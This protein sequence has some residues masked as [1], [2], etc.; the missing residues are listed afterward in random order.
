MKSGYFD[1]I[2]LGGGGA[3]MLAAVTAANL[4]KKVAIITKE[5][6]G[7]GNTRLSAGMMACPGAL[8]DDSIMSYIED[9]TLSGEGLSEPSLVEY[10]GEKS[11]NVLKDMEGYGILL[12]R[13]KEGY[14]SSKAVFPAGG[15][16]K[17]RTI[18]NVGGGLSISSALR[19][20]VLLHKISVFNETAALELL[21]NN[22]KI[23]GI[24]AVELKTGDLIYYFAPAVIIATGGCAA[25]YFPHTTNSRGV[26]G[27][28]LAI[29]L[30]AGAVLWDMEQMQAIP[31][32]LTYPASM[33][34][35]PIGEPSTA[36]PAGKLLNGAG[37]VI[38]EKNIHTMTRAALVKV[39]MLEVAAGRTTPEGGLFLDLTLNLKL[40]EGEKFY[41]ALKAGG[42]FE[43]VRFAYGKEAYQWK[44]PWSVLPTMH[45]TMGGIK[46]NVRG[47]TNVPGLFAVGEVQAGVHGAN[48]LGSVALSEIFTFGRLVGRN[49]ASYSTGQEIGVIEELEE[50]TIKWQKLLSG[51]GKH[52]PQFLKK[53]LQDTMWNLSGLLRTE[54]G[55]LESLA[56]LD[57]IEQAAESLCLDKDRILN[58]QLLDALELHHMLTVARAITLSALERQESRGAHL[59]LD[60]PEKDDKRFLAHTSVCIETRGKM[61]SGLEPLGYFS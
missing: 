21:K 45:Y 1:I 24:L 44:K 46:V 14:L 25:L 50:K 19:N 35:A 54:E 38:L 26:T 7:Y 31:F 10:L 29:G 9:I 2:C 3:G 52:T 37:N 61:K 30:K 4:G 27:D 16:K 5:A 49:A 22:G 57:K 23:C 8:S 28:G 32:G 60:F 48:R 12:N 58:R 6:T 59:R 15:H 18:R 47:E 11:P 33:I 39:I 43:P 56:E 40:P 17:S 13:D 53:Q 36:G 34:G 51:R 55:L 20:A 41:Q 42:I